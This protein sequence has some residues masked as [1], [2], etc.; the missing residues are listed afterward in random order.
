MH[1][2]LGNEASLASKIKDQLASQI[3]VLEQFEEFEKFH[4][5][6]NTMV[7]ELTAN[8]LH[9]HKMSF[10]TFDPDNY[11]HSLRLMPI[12]NNEISSLSEMG[13]GQ[14][15]I[16]T[17]TFAYV[18]AKVLHNNLLLIIEEPE[19]H[20]HPLAQGWLASSITKLCNDS[21]QILI[22]THSPE[23]VDILGFEGLVC[24]RSNDGKTLTRQRTIR[25]FV[26]EVKQM[27][28][29][30]TKTSEETILPYYASS[31]TKEILSGLFGQ[32]VVLVEGQ[33][34]Q[35]SLPVLLKKVGLDTMR[36]GISVISVMGKTNLAKWWRFFQ[37]FDYRVYLIFDKDKPGTDNYDRNNEIFATLNLDKSV[38]DNVLKSDAWFV[39]STFSVF[40]PDFEG[41]M[42]QSFSNYSALEAEA[43]SQF[44][45][46][47]PIAARYAASRL[48]FSENDAKAKLVD[49][50]SKIK[51]L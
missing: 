25:D 51:N 18:L 19:L 22:S 13:S 29:H 24:V 14:R 41:S 40:H 27:H 1:E 8:W 34:E 44:G 7:S 46:S 6:L 31:C 2:H 47:K 28:A 5:E 38:V 12:T 21:L 50:A 32:K 49:L 39:G 33:T 11:F 3:K 9:G 26:S 17:I 35:L 43:S 15:Q 42:Q 36:D 23:F 4:V 10:T 16:L 45:D 37:I 48:E 20:L 30:P